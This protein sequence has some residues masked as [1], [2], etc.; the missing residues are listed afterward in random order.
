MVHLVSHTVEGETI[1]EIVRGRETPIGVTSTQYDRHR[2]SGIE[3]QKE[4]LPEVPPY[5]EKLYWWAYVR[6]WAIRILER[7]WLVDL[8]LWGNYRR[9]CSD[10]LDTLGETLPGKTL[11]IACVYGDLTSKLNGRVQAGEGSLDVV[12]VLPVQLENLRH[13]LADDSVRLLVRDSSDLALPDA[14]YDR[15]LLYFL[16]H[17]QPPAI[18][19]RTLAEAFRVLK[20]GGRMIITDFARPARWHPLRFLWLPVLSRLEPYAVDLWRHELTVWLRNWHSKLRLTKKSFF[21][22]IYQII[23]IEKAQQPPQLGNASRISGRDGV[24]CPM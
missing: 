8:I 15:V 14:S 18:R 1:M 4:I 7:R 19:E 12:D 20:P 3:T 6:P 10:T 24:Q 2:S 5:L 23:A 17:E 9:L 11:Q 21:G 22:G 16:L 13:K